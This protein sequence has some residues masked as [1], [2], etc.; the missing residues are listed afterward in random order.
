MV[1]GTRIK[2][3]HEYGK[4]R[5]GSFIMFINCISERNCEKRENCGT[6]VGDITLTLR[7]PRM[8]RSDTLRLFVVS[9]RQSVNKGQKPGDEFGGLYTQPNVM[10]N[11]RESVTFMSIISMSKVWAMIL[12]CR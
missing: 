12:A 11:R 3:R 5:V 8:I 7:S 10:C 1:T 6:G 4:G 2:S 9:S